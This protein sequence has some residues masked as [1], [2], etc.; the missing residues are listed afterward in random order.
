VGKGDRKCPLRKPRR[1]GEDY[2]NVCLK[3][4]AW[5]S[6]N[7]VDLSQGKEIFKLL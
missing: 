1:D 2:I 4:T 7:W 3:E 5:E 6:L